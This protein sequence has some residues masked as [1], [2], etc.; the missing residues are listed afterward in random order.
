M[1]PVDR[2]RPHGSRP[3]E[4]RLRPEGEEHEGGALGPTIVLRKPGGRKVLLCHKGAIFAGETGL[5]SE[6]LAFQQVRRLGHLCGIAYA[7]IAGQRRM[8]PRHLFIHG[9]GHIAV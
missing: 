8:L 3:R 9:I 5:A 1:S 7:E 2:D 4:S 6:G